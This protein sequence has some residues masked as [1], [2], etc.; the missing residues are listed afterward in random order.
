MRAYRLTNGDVVIDVRPHAGATKQLLRCI[1][2]WCHKREGYCFKAVVTDK[3]VV[4]RLNAAETTVVYNQIMKAV[5]LGTGF[6]PEEKPWYEEVRDA[7]AS[8]LP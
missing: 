4:C 3:P 1:K 5:D 8:A 6:E 7:I 2:V